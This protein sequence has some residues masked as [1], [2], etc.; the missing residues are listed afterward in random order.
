MLEPHRDGMPKRKINLR[1]PS[2]TLSLLQN[3]AWLSGTFGFNCDIRVQYNN[4]DS[5]GTA[6]PSRF[7]R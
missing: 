6:N 4:E 1:L 2:Q 7:A 3:C 5:K